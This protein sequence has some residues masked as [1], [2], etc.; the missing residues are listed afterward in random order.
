MRCVVFGGGGFI[1]SHLFENL[2]SAGFDVT[3]FDRPEASGMDYFQSKKAKLVFGNFLN[4]DDLRQVLKKCDLAIHLVYLTVPQTSNDNPI[5][6]VEANLLGTLQFLDAARKAHVKKIIFSSSGGTVYGIPQE[7]PIKESHSTEPTSSYG[8]TKLAIEK[9]LNLYWIL[10]GLDYSILRIAN[11]YGE[12]QPITSTQGVIP[13]FLDKAIRQEEIT[14]WGDG[15]IVRDYIYAGDIASAFLKVA[16]INGKPRIFNI[17]AGQGYSLNDLIEIIRRIVKHPLRVKF[18]SGRLFDVPVNVL[19]I[20][21][22]HQ[23]LGWKPTVGLF[24]GIDR[25]HKWMLIK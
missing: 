8:I 2:S 21:L 15:S 11:A 5:Y 6:D 1:G 20:S 12:R 19:N 22:A 18:T 23:Y 17:G 10:Y 4:P 16:K 7:I 13:T 25:T 14:V 24:E 9:Y 3:V